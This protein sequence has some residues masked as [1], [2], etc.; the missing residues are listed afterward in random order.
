MYKLIFVFF[1]LLVTDI[2]S[3]NYLTIINADRTA[4]P[5]DPRSSN[6][7][8]QKKEIILDDPS[9]FDFDTYFSLLGFNDTAFKYEFSNDHLIVD[10]EGKRFF[11]DYLIREPQIETVEKIVYKE[12]VREIK[13]END[14]ESVS[15]SEA[16]KEGYTYEESYFRLHRDGAG[17]EKGTEIS[18]IILF[19]KDQADTNMQVTIDYSSLNPNQIG[20][21]TDYFVTKNGKSPFLIE[22]Y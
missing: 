18:E 14:N 10:M 8:F 5:F 11:Y 22:I 6:M 7:I 17:F 2:I 1:I 9:D 15:V 16:E 19:L 4:Y 21:Y 12:V 13:K 20:H 3:F